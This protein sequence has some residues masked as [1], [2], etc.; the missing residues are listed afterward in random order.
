MAKRVSKK[1]LL[2]LGSTLAFGSVGVITG[3]GL[4]SII[5]YNNQQNFLNQIN[6]LSEANF[7]TA[8][9]YN[10]ATADMFF[11]TTDLKSFHFGDVQKGQTI[12]PYGWL[13][14]FEPSVTI[15]RKI[16]LTGWNG[17]ILWVNDDYGNQGTKTEFNV[18]DMKYDFNTD[19]IFV[20]RTN[21][22][23]G[24]FNSGG[25]ITVIVDI[26][27]AKTG[28]KKDTV[29]ISTNSAWGYLGN[30]RFINP[31]SSDHLVRSKN[32]YSL[33]IISKPGAND[34][35]DVII[36]WTPN[37]LQLSQGWHNDTS[38]PIGNRWED[39]YNKIISM[40]ELVDN[41]KKM[42]T[43]IIFNRNGD[44]VTHS[45]PIEF[46]LRQA[47]T[48]QNRPGGPAWWNGNPYV[49]Q[50]D[51]LR[52][53]SLITNPFI[54]I[55]KNDFVVHLLVSDKHA[56]KGAEEEKNKVYHQ[57]IV[58][59]RNGNHIS[60]DV[61]EDIT[62]KF[63]IYPDE[64]WIK[65]ADW[66]NDFVNANL[67]INRNMF[68]ANSVVFAFPYAAGGSPK[69]PI[70]NV[71]QISINPNDGKINWS[72]EKK[73]FIL[74]FGKE[75]VDYWK[76]NE[77][78]YNSNSNLNKIYPFPGS[79]RTNLNHNY[80]R[81]IS[82]SPFDNTIL[83]AAKPN[84][85]DPIF[86]QT[87]SNGNK[88]ASFWIGDFRKS[89]PYRP[90]VI[91]NDN[92]LDGTVNSVMT[93]INDIYSKG[94]TFDLRSLTGQSFNLYF[95][96]AG[97]GRND[98]YANSNFLT[99][100]IGLLTD[101][102]AK[103]G[104][105]NIWFGNST[106]P[107]TKPFNQM[108]TGI[109]LKSYSTLIFSRAN[110]EK[111]Y[112]RTWQNIEMAGNFLTGNF[113]L[114]AGINDNT[115]AIARN[116]TSTLNDGNFFSTNK[117]VDLVS[118]WIDKDNTLPT[119]Y[120][121]LLVKRPEI[122][123]RGETIQNQLPVMTTYSFVNRDFLDDKTKANIWIK[124][125]TDVQKNKLVFQTKQNLASASYQ[126]FSSWKN[127]I[128]MSSI[129]STT[130]NLNASE[131]P[132]FKGQPTWYDRRQPNANPNPFGI[133][134]NNLDV[135]GKKPLRMLL[136]IAKPSNPP[137]WFNLINQNFFDKYPLQ[138]DAVKG[139]T[140]FETVLQKYLE[141]K[142]QKIDLAQNAP[143]A[144][145]LGNLKIDAF[146]DINPGV[147]S[148]SND[149]TIYKKGSKKRLI[150]QNSTGLRIIYEDNYN[151]R[152]REIYNQSQISYTQFS[153]GGFGSAVKADVQTSWV[154]GRMPG[155]T[156]KLKTVIN[157]QNFQD[158]LVRKSTTE[159]KIFTFDY[160]AATNNQNLVI[161]AIDKSWLRPRLLNFQRL[162]NMTPIFEYFDESTNQW[163]V[164]TTQNDSSMA[165]IWSDANSN[166][167]KLSASGLTNIHKLRLRLKPND[168]VNSTDP[169]SFV[170]IDNYSDTENKFI[171]DEQTTGIQRIDV[172]KAWFDQVTLDNAT[173]TLASLGV[174]DFETF[175]NKIFEKSA[176]IKRNPE[177]RLKVKLMYKWGNETTLYDKA[178]IANLIQSRLNDFNSTD[179]GVFALWNG[180]TG[181]K[182]QAFFEKVDQTVSFVVGTNLNPP[183][184]DLNGFVRST[185]NNVVNLGPY[186]SELTSN[187]INAT[188]SNVVGEFSGSTI[189]FPPKSGT[190]G[191]GQFAGKTYQ[192]IKDILA[193]VGVSIQYKKWQP[194][195]T[196]SGW[197]NDLNQV[198]TYDP[199]N[200]Q[201][202]IGFKTN[203]GNQNWN[204]KLDNNG[205][206]IDNNSTEFTLNL[207]LPKLVKLPTDDKVNK[208]IEDFNKENIFGGNS[209]K[210]TVGNLAAGKKIV[211]DVL[212]TASSSNPSGY[213]GLENYLILKFK[214]GS[215]DWMEASILQDWL[216][217]QT[218]IDQNSNLLKMKVELSTNNDFLLEEALRDNE[219]NLLPENNP[220]IKKYIHGTKLEQQ[221]NQITASGTS[222]QITYSYPKELNQVITN[223]KDG[224]KVQYTYNQN[225]PVTAS[226]NSRDASTDW[227][228]V[229]NN[230]LPTTGIPSTV[231]A[232]YV[233]IMVTDSNIY[234]YGPDDNGNKIK[235][236][237]DLTNLRDQINVESSW[238]NLPFPEDKTL[239]LID[240]S[241]DKINIY[242]QNVFNS[243][244]T[245]IQEQKDKL[246][247]KYYFGNSTN[248]M[249]KNQLFDLIRKY[250]NSDT[251]D[252]LQLWN[253]YQGEK[254]SATFVKKN[255]SGNYD[256]I[257]G[258]N[259]P[260]KQLLNTSKVVTTIDLISLVKWLE[261]VKV[262]V[263]KNGNNIGSLNFP[264]TNVP[265][266]SFDKKDWDKTEQV[267]ESLAIRVQ[268]QEM[269][270]TTNS[271]IWNED[272]NS[273]KSYDNRAQF[274]IRFVLQKQKG[275]NLIVKVRQNFDLIGT[276]GQ[277]KTSTD[278]IVNLNVPKI[279]KIDN[280]AVNTFRNSNAFSGNTKRIEVD[281][282]KLTTLIT[283]IKNSTLN[284][285]IPSIASA[286]LQVEFRFGT[287]G[288]FKLLNEWK[289]DLS[290]MQTDQITNQIQIKF[291][292]PDQNS[293]EWAVEIPAN[294]DGGY[295]VAPENNTAVPIY[296]HDQGIEESIKTGT[297]ITGDNTNLQINFPTGDGFTVDTNN[298]ISGSKGNGLKIQF[299]LDE[300][301]D[302][303]AANGWSDQRPNSAPIGTN[304]I[305]MRIVPADNWH[306]YEKKV[307][308]PY[309]KIQVNFKIAQRLIV[310]KQW[311]NEFQLGGPS[312]EIADLTVEKINE[313]IGKIQEKVKTDNN[314]ISDEIAKKVSIKFNYKNQQNLTAE[315]LYEAIKTDREAFSSPNLGIVQLWNGIKGDKINATFVTLSNDVIIEDA[316]GNQQISDDINTKNI[317]TKINLENYINVLKT[318]KTTVQRG[319]ASGQ[320]NSFTPPPMNGTTG[321]FA[322]KSY[323]EI[324]KRLKDV[325][326]EIQFSSE[327]NNTQW[328][329]KEAIKTYNPQTA[330][331][332]L[333]FTNPQ[334]NNIK[335]SV[336]NGNPIEE[337][338]SNKTNPIKLPLNI[339]KQINIKQNDL[340]N[341]QTEI[342]FSGDTKR[343]EFNANAS[344]ALITKILQRNSNEANGDPTFNSA[345]LIIEFKIGDTDWKKPN[346]LKGYLS[347]ISDDLK[348]RSIK[349]HFKLENN[350]NSDWELEAG[351]DQERE[352][353]SDNTSPLKI[354]VNDNGILNDLRDTTFSGTNQA[355]S[356]HWKSGISVNQKDGQLR[357]NVNNKVSG[358]GL[359]LAYSFDQ[360]D[361][362]NEQPNSYSQDV[363]R[364]YLKI[365]LEDPDKYVYDKLTEVIEL[366][367]N[368]PVNVTL[369]KSWLNQQFIPNVQSL[370]DFI[371]NIK[372]ILDE[373]EKKVISA[374]QQDGIS[375]EIK[376]KFKIQYTFNENDNSPLD[377]NQ[378]IQKIQSYQTDNA[379]NNTFGILQLWNQTSGVKIKALFSD[380][381]KNDNFNI[382]V[383]PD[384]QPFLLDTSNVQTTIN[385]S[386]VLNWLTDQNMKVPIEEGN[387]A[388]SI[389]EIKIPRTSGLTSDPFNDREWAQI[390]KALS[391]FGITIHYKADGVQT[392]TWGPLSSIKVYDPA[393]GQIEF[394]FKFDQTKSKNIK[395]QLNSTTHD[396]AT[397]NES[398]VYKFKLKVKLSLIV[399]QVK[400]NQFLQNAN[401][402]GDTKFI[403]INQ[404]AEQTLI[405]A[406]KKANAANNPEFN[407]AILK[408]QYYLGSEK[409]QKIEWKE[410]DQFKNDLEQ[411]TIDQKTNRVV[412]RLSID[413]SQDEKFSVANTTYVLHDNNQ[414][415]GAWTVKYFINK[416]NLE[417]SAGSISVRGTSSNI[418]WNYDSF[419]T[420]RV[421]K[422]PQQNG[423][424]K[425]Y[426]KNIYGQRML[427]VFFSTNENINYGDNESDNLDEISSKWV[428]LE[429]SQFLDAWNVSKLFVKLVPM[430]G[431]IYEA[432]KDGSAN[433][434]QISLENLKLE[435]KVN[436][437][438]LNTTLNLTAGKKYLHELTVDNINE[439][440]TRAINTVN[441]NR[442]KV[443]V[444]FK[445]RNKNFNATQLFK[446]IQ[447]AL[448]M[449]GTTP[450][451]IVQLWNGASGE[452]I[453]ARF[454][455]KESA[456]EQYIL[457][458]SENE[459]NDAE[460]FVP[461]VTNDI[462]TLIDLKA[463]VK[464][465]TKLKINVVLSNQVLYDLTPLNKLEMPQIPRGE[466]SELQGLTWENFEKR[467][468]GFG[469][470]IQAR[471]KVKGTNT[472][473]WTSI[474]GVKKYDSNLLALEL[475]F[476][477]NAPN[478]QNIVLSVAQNEDVNIGTSEADLPI[479]EM[480]LK[481]PAKVEVN[482]ALLEKFI[483]QEIFR[484]N[485]KYLEIVSEQPEADLIKAII[486]QNI[487]N[488]ADI[489]KEL[490]GRLEVQYYLGKNDPTNQP[491]NNWYSAQGLKTFLET[492]TRDQ[493]TNKIW[494]RL[495]I[496]ESDNPNA[497]I[498]Q[499][500]Q[501]AR[502]LSNEQIDAAAKIKIYINETGFSAQISKLKAVGST[503]K[504]EIR[505]LT[506]WE[507]TVPNGLEIGYSK[508]LDPDE[509]D[510]N[511]WTQNLPNTLT[512]DKKLWV[513]FKV[514]D[515]YVYQ[516]AINNSNYGQKHQIN[517]DGIK[518]IIKLKSEWLEKILITGSTKNAVINEQNVLDAI[519][520]EGVLPTNQ[521][522][523]I[524]L[525]YSIKATD[526]WLNKNDFQ[527]KLIELNGA[528][529][530][531]NFILR[532]DDLQVRFN[533]K[534]NNR[535]DNYGLNIDNQ[536]VDETNRN[537]FNKDI[538]A[539][540]RN[541]N[542]KGVINLEHLKYFS[543]E[544]FKI[545][546]STTE[547]KLIIPKRK[548]LNEL[549]MP[550][551]SDDLFD[552]QFSTVKKP[553]DEWEWNNNQSIL[554]KTQ[555][556]SEDGLIKQGIT[557]GAD[558]H[559]AIRFIAKDSNYDVFAQNQDQ[560]NGY[561]LDISDN[562]KITVEIINPF[563]ANNKTL[564]LWTR[565][566]TNG[567]NVAKYYQGQGGFKIAV[568]N[569]NT[570]IVENNGQ[571]SAQEFL[572]TTSS[573]TDVERNALELVYHVFGPN[574]SGSE[575]ERVEKSIT[576][577]EDQETWK[578]F[579]SIKENGSDW[580]RSLDLKVGDNVAVALR[581]KETFANQENPFILK[582]DDHS[583]I[584]PI[585]KDV[586]GK[587]QKPA[588]LSGYKVNTDLIDI[589][590]DNVILSNM[591]SSQLPPLDGWTE[592]QRVNLQAD[593][594]DNY[595]GV[596]LKMQVY[597]EFHEKPAGQILFSGSNTKLVKRLTDKDDNDVID[598]GNY[599]DK[600]NQNITDKDGEE[601]KIYKKNNR[602]SPP[603]KNPNVTKDRMLVN[604]GGG[605][606]RFEPDTNSYERGRLSLFRNQDVDL[607]LVANKGEGT[608]DLPDFYLDKEKVIPLKESISNQIKFPIENEKKISYAWNYEDFLPGQIKYKSPG[609]NNPNPEDGNA[610]IDTIYKLIKKIGNSEP[611]EITGIS[612]NEAFQKIEQQLNED[613]EGQLRFETIHQ[614]SN[615]SQVILKNSNI[616]QFT[617]LK[618]KDR[619][620]LRIVAVEDD[621]FY[622]TEDA[623]LVINVNGLT[624]A[625]PD[626]NKLQYLR[627]KQGGV[628]NGQGS[629]KVLVSNPEK[630]DEDDQS[631]L[632]GWKFLIRVWTKDENGVPQIKIPWSDDPAQIKG[633]SNGDRVEWKLVSSDGNPVKD[634]YYNTIALDH[635]QKPDGNVDYQFGQVNYPKGQ[636]SYDI[637]HKGIGA[638][639]E[640][641]NQYP[642]NSGFVISN[643][644]PTF[645]V[646]KIDQS[647]FEAIIKQL[648]PFYVGLNKQGT[649]NFDKKYFENDY[650]VN[651]KGEIYLKDGNQSKLN[652]EIEELVE[653][654]IKEF[655]NNITFFTQD[656][657]LYPYQNGFK[658][659][660]NDVNINNHLANG[661][662]VWAQFDMVSFKD[663]ND[664]N[665]RI[666]SGT[667]ISS[668]TWQLADVS[669]LKNIIDPMSPF[670]YVL[671]A[672]A[673]IATLGTASLIAFLVAR[674]KKLKGKN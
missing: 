522:D 96:Q 239:N 143:S 668:I 247:I 397:E 369:K 114:N 506:E 576:D 413:E 99:S 72:G 446:E 5:D 375:D 199:S 249:D 433:K 560:P 556:I 149:L 310:N 188:A 275:K 404:Q 364:V 474:A 437:N 18:Y 605:S 516:N 578:P 293:N 625:A 177:L 421:E 129:G 499:V 596:D 400:I 17:E 614:T 524:E 135:N 31:G 426:I 441:L 612:I 639:P 12:T 642:E 552:I 161:T 42:V 101:V 554:E 361:W 270:P 3:F 618:N 377:Q 272:L 472:E 649:I 374:A 494:F 245:L 317:Y 579:D 658:F 273:I 624:E 307:D 348:S 287:S 533:I 167:F 343:I 573:L 297:N 444:E 601:V 235:G 169:N 11:D 609:S 20:A 52:N 7:D 144:V 442:D 175:E 354:Y 319:S 452:K 565:E 383:D 66:S 74:P 46:D 561:I 367:L 613:F 451:N 619:I 512:S 671:I 117:S 299:S 254:I 672:L 338:N 126:I 655:L 673:G 633:L 575:I 286:P 150:V 71:A 75:I 376:T 473:A 545:I 345:P 51:F 107:T 392:A 234:V 133:I 325:G 40:Y 208:L 308:G 283:Q 10:K 490:Q 157:A 620:I 162:I 393:S 548:E 326:I 453:E 648:N 408:V 104:A 65:N 628:I 493:N 295:T 387:A 13:G 108:G 424:N 651:T 34:N 592:L 147:I 586:T 481:A 8:P 193:N 282:A 391:D 342:N 291:S 491:N 204:I 336:D 670:W 371:K 35:N 196:W 45:K 590:K 510:V 521:P 495:N 440:V 436:P 271:N 330:V 229:T 534:A 9:D 630:D 58:F 362:T 244:G 41:Y 660:A 600:N 531:K 487:A 504:F 284:N 248:L 501:S 674:H 492:Q 518:V 412:F 289:T 257:W 246:S 414:D 471:P 571:Q 4:K 339:P 23:N 546:G 337:G 160:D 182:I 544:N 535:N 469:V 224:L 456:R 333:A 567:N 321:Q 268:Y 194:G 659:S 85:V 242:E 233:R 356:W 183:E 379:N 645:E 120:N 192:E 159:G 541:D 341:F 514:E 647:T 36:T 266:S 70:F 430:T 294:T 447:T 549:F 230:N 128:R 81:L 515:G 47:T 146:M 106:T 450:K 226:N 380:A 69:V 616:Y 399:D 38:D 530:S 652:N 137:Q 349:Y 278:I 95:N 411:Q 187:I 459:K 422:A 382:T 48:F 180:T 172:N 256:L 503:D 407:S 238:L 432:Q 435:I 290:G 595:L 359:K 582:G 384:E 550:Y 396:G 385:F 394:K 76:L 19:L 513:R 386:G 62:V 145:G 482:D 604:L 203:A 425:I 87:N 636:G 570:F 158:N 89:K 666:N 260:Q 653:I 312:I 464:E 608:V 577:Y 511:S 656:P 351:A 500:D 211:S 105:G 449:N 155:P 606:F 280:A 301:L 581:V 602:L 401:I 532:R 389:D 650:W 189:Q 91:Y 585:M 543:L 225:L 381:N 185:V 476:K 302:V 61:T 314:N 15:S 267:L 174:Q 252:I 110:L 378:L 415:A 304:K 264:Q 316:N 419:G 186:I 77:S 218:D 220:K 30:S 16:A 365:Q 313:W 215:S 428:S 517:T 525:Q 327:L 622:V 587:M 621:L 68:D 627:V 406:I 59:D 124:N 646:F 657:V 358:V 1:L 173:S 276:E 212:K 141:E 170:Q 103:D 528:K 263:N 540:G 25:A 416:A 227:V 418:I 509:A 661:D 431:Y 455:L 508:E 320:M 457:I 329:D 122:K 223:A 555:L 553:N 86:D 80:N 665:S 50:P 443:D 547:P 78:S 37:F 484:G 599:K 109:D 427:Q 209:Y 269:T 390:E 113:Q 344:Q 523:L 417:N 237:V 439:F 663:E 152:W 305:F 460:R 563:T 485:T 478:G 334:D 281:S 298:T 331:L 251:F 589:Q 98:R 119:N 372:T 29:N 632:K 574:P 306:I 488:N 292:I 569:K 277:D 617:N 557:I 6:G 90:F 454:I 154:N 643:L 402:K 55:S 458:D 667:N 164:L 332:Y 486:D 467:L 219:F 138:K 258:Q 232:I 191:S 318:N 323:D 654:P 300:S 603:K 216:L 542:F 583:M 210:L 631:I 21:S 335:L 73:S 502:V 611:I 134:N 88:W 520:N 479:F 429:P 27:D 112:P 629:F 190:S 497:Q 537:N 243:I 67:R 176:A 634:A 438:H 139:E 205:T 466:L 221:L 403:Q 140:A 202:K 363:N 519:T 136:Q 153:Q 206:E 461:I 179:Q 14:V 148:N 100:K 259:D 97:S 405:D 84:L 315:K 207:R 572:N 562:V 241:L 462:K 370:D 373:Y 102:L 489:F 434:H 505:G 368:L 598:K 279:I 395:L 558:K 615:G 410:W 398:Q 311:I 527:N 125:L 288:N 445:F 580:S 285:Q 324:S 539:T 610:Q 240:I 250:K 388:N 475:R 409:D 79:N 168:L 638:Y 507:A 253:N 123:V 566:N 222:T 53:Y 423:N 346:E 662:H 56:K 607:S 33:D 115:R 559:F 584:L 496:K 118:N 347:S 352:L 121:R 551:A 165:R 213:N 166:T 529:D 151:E 92:S 184:N 236:T 303:N 498:F 171:S 130:N 63:S 538:V 483:K 448:K 127:Q 669:G 480:N 22:D 594:L 274:K 163:K 262:N 340:N 197:L 568:A 142:T 328:L 200:P 593:Q 626:Q 39:G 195:G 83:Y 156:S 49:N 43:N 635:K 623:P 564:G 178:E 309:V 44:T 420:S 640:N 265:G 217:K 60:R 111:W 201:V 591:F 355:L 94:L 588:R 214:L 477:V 28:L 641:D 468:A 261:Q 353:F 526:K 2:G 228:D 536:I 350:A 357:K 32:L 597:T 644:K 26:L 64:A 131:D 296:V 93:T 82:V 366:E 181:I 231:K 198:N 465:L 255:E 463:I 664:D 322:G 132:N 116:F 24:L 360:K 54:T 637:I 470:L 57:S